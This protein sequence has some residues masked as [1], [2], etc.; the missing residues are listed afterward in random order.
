MRR[1]GTLG[2]AL[3]GLWV[4]AMSPLQLT[5]PAMWVGGMLTGEAEKGELIGA[6]VMTIPF[7]ISLVVG[8][9]LIANRDRIAEE[10][11]DDSELDLLAGQ[12]AWLPTGVILLGL[13]MSVSGLGGLVHGIADGIQRAHLIGIRRGGEGVLGQQLLNAIPVLLSR[14]IML[15]AGLVFVLRHR[16]VVD[17][18]S[19]RQR[20]LP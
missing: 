19:S 15:A 20:R 10:W 17:W 11:F 3:I 7:A 1:L 6:L 13:W 4:I 12:A 16:S 2:I 18:I 9:G 8:F 14:L 5:I